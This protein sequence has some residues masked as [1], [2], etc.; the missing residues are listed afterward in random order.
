M[1]QHLRQLP[2]CDTVY[3]H[4][5]CHIPALTLHFRTSPFFRRTNSFHTTHYIHPLYLST[6]VSSWAMTVSP[7]QARRPLRTLPNCP[8]FCGYCLWNSSTACKPSTNLA[9]SQVNESYPVHH[10]EYCNRVQLTRLSSTLDTWYYSS[11]STSTR[12]GQSTCSP[13]KGLPATGSKSETDYTWWIH[14]VASNSTSTVEG[15][16]RQTTSKGPNRFQLNIFAGLV[17]IIC[18]ASNQMCEPFWIFG[19]GTHSLLAP[20]FCTVWLLLFS[21]WRWSWTCC[22]VTWTWSPSRRHWSRSF[23]DAPA[24][25]TRGFTS[26][27]ANDK[28]HFVDWDVPFLAASFTKGIQFAQSSCWWFTNTWQYSSILPFVHS[29]CPFIWGSKAVHILRSISRWLKSCPQKVETNC[30]PVSDTIITG[31]PWGWNDFSQKQSCQS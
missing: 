17:V 20:S 15:D 16:I 7:S 4:P 9:C 24:N 14:I 1:P 25:D 28:I 18:W 6:F 22:I 13:T 2:Y 27:T 23:V 29:V 12:G 21:N 10:I 5:L 19:A 11:P 3:H 31:R 30:G 8:G 26:W